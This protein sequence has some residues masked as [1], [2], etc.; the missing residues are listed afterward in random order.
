M[1]TLEHHLPLN[2]RNMNSEGKMIKK[3]CPHSHLKAVS[4]TVNGIQTQHQAGFSIPFHT[5]EEFE[6]KENEMCFTETL[7]TQN[8]RNRWERERER[9]I[10]PCLTLNCFTSDRKKILWLFQL[11]ITWAARQ[12]LKEEE[13]EEEEG[14]RGGGRKILWRKVRI[15]V[16]VSSPLNLST[17]FSLTLHH[18]PLPHPFTLRLN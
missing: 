11:Y 13:E 5:I 16:I 9:E 3:M 18:H 17:F 1:F 6:A 4:G 15:E 7:R 12:I 14:G 2:L 10:V 8:P